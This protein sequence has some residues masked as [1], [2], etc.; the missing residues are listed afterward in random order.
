MTNVCFGIE[1]ITHT[2]LGIKGRS[3]MNIFLGT[4]GNNLI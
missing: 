2:F 1:N 4:G 3:I